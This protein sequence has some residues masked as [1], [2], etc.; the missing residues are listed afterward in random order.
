MDRLILQVEH[1]LLQVHNANG[2]DSTATLNLTINPST[3]SSV[4]VTE[5]DTYSWNGQTYTA[6]GVYTN[7]TTNS[8]GCDSTATLN[9]TINN[10]VTSTNNQTICYGGSY[11]IGNSTY[12]ASGTYTDVF[13]AANGCDSTVTTNLTILPGLN[14]S[15]QSSGSSTACSGS[16]VTLSMSGFASPTNTY[17]WNDVNGVAICELL[18]HYTTTTTGTYS[19][20]VTNPSGCTATSSGLAITI[21]SLSP[22]SGLST[23]NIQ[24]DAATMNWSAVTDADHYNIRMRVQGSSSWSVALNYLYGT[25]KEKFNLTSSTTYE[26]EIRSACSFDNSSVSAWSSTESFTTASPCTAP[27]NATTTGIGLTDATLAWDAVSGAL[28][29]IVRYKKVNQGWGTFVFD[30]V[31][32]N[33]FVLSSLSQGTAYHWQVKSMCNAN[34]TNNSGFTSLVAF[35]TGACN[36]SLNI[37]QTNVGCY[38]GSDGA[39]DLS[40]SGGSGSYAYL[41]SDGSTT[42]DLDSLSAGTY[43]VTVTDNNRGC[44]ESLTVVVTEPC[45]HYF[46]QFPIYL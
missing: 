9:L 3:T 20:T 15:I 5:C 46:C 16:T 40:V 25:S 45:G 32:T 23:S 1:I 42:E 17:Q 13:T 18:Q 2:C 27:L 21:I 6:S 4:D 37:S 29:Y 38:G 31:T 36:L 30:T 34:G 41:W 43:S 19:L 28:E 39:I 12:T 33:S 35:N 14:V 8:N 7:V 26:W 11:T 44:T 10:S 22:P 24:I